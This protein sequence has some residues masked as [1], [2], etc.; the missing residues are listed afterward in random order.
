[1]ILRYTNKISWTV[2]V[3]QKRTLVIVLFWFRETGWV[4]G[5]WNTVE[6][7]EDQNKYMNHHSGGVTRGGTKPGRFQKCFQI[8]ARQ[9]LAV[10]VC[11]LTN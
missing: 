7:N 6:V 11:R 5:K 8:R 3:V 1:M 2:R 9:Q 4:E 10:L